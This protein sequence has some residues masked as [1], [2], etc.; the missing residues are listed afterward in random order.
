MPIKEKF[1]IILV[2]FMRQELL[3]ILLNSIKEQT[4]HPE[5]L[6]VV[7]NENSND[8]SLLVTSFKEQLSS[9]QIIYVPMLEN[10][11]GAGGFSKGVEVAYEKGAEWI[12]IMDDDVRIFPDAVERLIPWL[13]KSLE[14]GNR[15][16]QVCRKNYDHSEFYWQ[17]DFKNQLGIP[18]PIAPA[19]FSKGESYKEINTICFEGGLIH[20]SLVEEIGIPDYR[21]FIYWD[22]TIYGYL[23]SKVTQLIL[24]NETVMERTREL[25]NMKIGKIRK[26]NSTSDMARFYIMRNRGYMAQY[27]KIHGDYQPIIFAIGTFLTLIKEVIRLKFSDNFSLSLKELFRGMSEAKKLRE[28]KDWQP[29]PK[30]KK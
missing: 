30:L 23:A 27:L 20:R 16:L 5:F 10:T 25:K 21:F 17:Y 22:D 4:V 28:D 11:G 9:S 19:G 29:M 13:E 14:N 2:T 7:D 8:T 15:A 18:N 26:L 24:I 6:V 12:W 3:E 1:A